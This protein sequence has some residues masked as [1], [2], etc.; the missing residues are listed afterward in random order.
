MRCQAELGRPRTDEARQTIA[1]HH[2][3]PKTNARSARSHLAVITQKASAGCDD[4]DRLAFQASLP[5]CTLVDPQSIDQMRIG[6]R[7]TAQAIANSLGDDVSHADG[8]DIAKCLIA[9]HGFTP[10][11]SRPF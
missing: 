9:A 1:G 3:P 8:T 10:R 2:L 5:G 11:I 6:R 4:L 7:A